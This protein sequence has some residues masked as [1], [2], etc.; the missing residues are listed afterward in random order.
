M[1]HVTLTEFL[2][3]RIAGDDDHGE[4][5]DLYLCVLGVFAVAL[6]ALASYLTAWI[7]S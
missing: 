1:A 4:V 3:A 5:G 2:L 7:Y 6:L